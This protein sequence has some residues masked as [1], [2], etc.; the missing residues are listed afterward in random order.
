MS[1]IVDFQHHYTPKELADAK[2]VAGQ[3]GASFDEN[4]NPA[5]L[6]NPL[7]SDLDEHVRMMNY[8]GIDM[9]VLSCADGFDNPD[10][11]ACAYPGPLAPAV[12]MK[13]IE[14]LL[15]VQHPFVG[16]RCGRDGG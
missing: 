14:P 10:R 13:I 6:F 7:L 9:A 2:G 15:S 4:G 1:I 12:L 11:A 5:Y 16:A 8:A 3:L